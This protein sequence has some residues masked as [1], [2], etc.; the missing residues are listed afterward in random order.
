MLLDDYAYSKQY[1]L[2]KQAIDKL[3]STLNLS[4][5]TLPTGQGLIIKS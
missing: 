5:L 3:G 2:Q 1:H 4:V